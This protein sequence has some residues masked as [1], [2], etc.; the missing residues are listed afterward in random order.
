MAH[1][2]MDDAREPGFEAPDNAQERFDM[3]TA[4][5]HAAAVGLD[6]VRNEVSDPKRRTS[7]VKLSGTEDDLV[8]VVLGYFPGREA[9]AG[10]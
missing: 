8:C 6:H 9:T 4:R 5:T 2:R 3:V 1:L 7:D 10:Q